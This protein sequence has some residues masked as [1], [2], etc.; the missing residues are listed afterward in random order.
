MTIN[1]IKVGM[2]YYEPKYVAPYNELRK[3]ISINKNS[4]AGRIVKDMYGG[5]TWREPYAEIVAIGLTT[6]EI[7]KFSVQSITED[8]KDYLKFVKDENE[9]KCLINKVA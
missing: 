9:Y 5:I 7:T 4:N 2:L 6:G 3:V 1:D 8:I